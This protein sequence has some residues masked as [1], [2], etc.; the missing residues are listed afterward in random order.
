MVLNEQLTCLRKEKGLSQAE[1]AEVLKVS[2][3]AISKWESG[4]AVPASEN[5]IKLG[6]LYG[7]SI[8][9]LAGHTV[10]VTEETEAQYPELETQ[11][12]PQTEERKRGLSRAAKWM[13]CGACTLLLAMMCYMLL[14]QN[15]EKVSDFDEMGQ[16]DV[17]DLGELKEFDF[18]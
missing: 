10:E 18:N 12:V 3:Q 16:A 11:Q 15:N 8:D 7:V 13:L 4:M 14:T 1:V 17:L 5:L 9:I 2:R 6:K